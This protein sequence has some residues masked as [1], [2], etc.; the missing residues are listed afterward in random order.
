EGRRVRGVRGRSLGAR[1]AGGL[2]WGRGAMNW[3]DERGQG[4]GGDPGAQSRCF[5]PDGCDDGTAD[6]RCRRGDSGEDGKPAGRSRG[7][8][9]GREQPL[10]RRGGNGRVGGVYQA[11]G[12][13]SKGG[14]DGKAGCANEYDAQAPPSDDGQGESLDVLDGAG[15]DRH[16]GDDSARSEGC[17]QGAVKGSP[18]AQVALD[19]ERKRGLERSVQAVEHNGQGE[20]PGDQWSSQDRSEFHSCGGL[21]RRSGGPGQGGRGP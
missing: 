9:S 4:D 18:A 17:P 12:S 14:H 10:E 3:G 16:A 1:I 2:S 21:A 15:A 6:S 7:K 8:L 5:W 19:E 20:Q 13:H 11:A